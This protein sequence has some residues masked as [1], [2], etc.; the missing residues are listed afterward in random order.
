MP[1][2]NE[3]IR[4]DHDEKQTKSSDPAKKL[5]RRREREQQEFLKRCRDDL[6]SSI[7]DFPKATDRHKINISRIL[8]SIHKASWPQLSP[9]LRVLPS[10]TDALPLNAVIVFGG[11]MLPPPD[12]IIN[13]VA[14][15][16]EKL[17]FDL[18]S[19]ELYSGVTTRFEKLWR[20]P[21][22]P[23]HSEL[24]ADFDDYV[25]KHRAFF[26]PLGTETDSPLE[27]SEKL[28]PELIVAIERELYFIEGRAF[29]FYPT[30]QD[31]FRGWVDFFSFVRAYDALPD[32]LKLRFAP[33]YMMIQTP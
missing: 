16:S 22:E 24:K 30:P 21:Q 1:S 25:N 2:L 18:L 6:T 3:S 10:A 33:Y 15:P 8:A 5:A 20:N 19:H 7:K 23:T 9:L 27:I 13:G 17:F 26:D 11:W 4:Q 29:I 12:G 28:V 32:K 14:P 31:P